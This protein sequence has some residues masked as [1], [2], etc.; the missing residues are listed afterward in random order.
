MEK[1]ESWSLVR[2]AYATLA[3]VTL[4][5]GI[6]GL[7]LPLLPTTVFVLIAAWAAPKGSPRLNR[8][9]RHHPQIGPLLE[10]WHTKGAV[11]RTAKWL[12]CITMSLSWMGLFFMGMNGIVLTVMAVL[13]IAVATFLITRP[14]PE[15]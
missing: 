9:I 5:L 14:E 13:F 3:G 7:F 2:M 1:A 10:A 8:W 15:N 11:P 4:A 6:V 12:A